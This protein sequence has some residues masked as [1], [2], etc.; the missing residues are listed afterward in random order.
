MKETSKINTMRQYKIENI[1]EDIIDYKKQIENNLHNIENL[2]A[3]IEINEEFLKVLNNPLYR[4]KDSVFINH[5]DIN[6]IISS[7]ESYCEDLNNY[8]NCEDRDLFLNV[9]DEIT[10]LTDKL[11]LYNKVNG[12]KNSVREK[13]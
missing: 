1:Q 3:Q 4:G 5:N 6:L 13:V 10:I 7:L 9:Q 11:I 2:K 12:E 8:D